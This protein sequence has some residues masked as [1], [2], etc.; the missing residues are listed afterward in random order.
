[1]RAIGYYE[2]MTLNIEGVEFDDPIVEKDR[3]AKVADTKS[4][5]EEWMLSHTKVPLRWFRVLLGALS[6]L[7]LLGTIIFLLLTYY[8][9]SPVT[10]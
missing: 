2:G 6:A 10:P 5:T 8:V 4:G 7:C 9:K 3:V 1:M